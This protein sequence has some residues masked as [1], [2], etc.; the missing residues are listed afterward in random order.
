LN[1]NL[2]FKKITFLLNVMMT[3]SLQRTMSWNK[4][5]LLT[6]IVMHLGIISIICNLNSIYT[7]FGIFCSVLH[8][9]FHLFRRSENKML[10]SN[11]VLVRTDK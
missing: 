8:E 4:L 3:F 10:F 7:Y 6:N 5:W 1:W 11:Q 9:I 2:G